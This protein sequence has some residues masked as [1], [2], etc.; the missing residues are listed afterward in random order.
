MVGRTAVASE[1]V[2]K[3][4]DGDVLATART[5]HLVEKRDEILILDVHIKSLEPRHDLLCGFTLALIATTPPGLV[6]TMGWCIFAIFG[7]QKMMIIIMGFQKMMGFQKNSR[8]R[9]RAGA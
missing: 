7:R 9:A 1:K 4:I 8:A 3:V 5:V 6:Y 2:D